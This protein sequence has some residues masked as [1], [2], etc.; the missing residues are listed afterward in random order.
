MPDRTHAWPA[1]GTIIGHTS[2]GP[3]FAIAGGAEDTPPAPAAPA[4]PPAVPPVGATPPAAPDPL[5]AP[6]GEPGLRA[7]QAERERAA[8][9]ERERDELARWKA[10]QE[11]QNL[12]E[13]ERER[14]RATAA[15][16]ALATERTQRL[17]L[18]AAAEHSIPAEYLLLLTATDEAALKQQ[19][20]S[21][22]AL[23][24][25][26]SAG[27]TPPAPLPGQGAPVTPPNTA[28]VAAGMEIYRKQHQKQN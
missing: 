17:R 15:E 8:A 10:E 18:Q 12:T 6:L 5:D 26:K 24:A 14:A 25:A 20:E 13:L 27:P 11:Q 1:P 4:A 22:A 21:V 9:A 19:A 3:V 28:S 2:R 7:L 16:E 23:V